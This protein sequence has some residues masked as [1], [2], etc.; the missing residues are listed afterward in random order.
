MFTILGVAIFAL[1]AGI[2]GTGLALKIEEVERN[3]IRNRKKRAATILIQ[4]AW[5]C[6]KAHTT[7][8]LVS[9][10]FRGRPMAIYKNHHY[11]STAHKFLAL[12]QLFVARNRFREL[13][14]PLDVKMVM[15]SYSDGQTEVLLRTKLIQ[16][17]IEELTRR[18]EMSENRVGNMSMRVETK[19]NTFEQRINHIRQLLESC[20]RQ[21]LANHL[22][23]ELLRGNNNRLLQNRKNHKQKPRYNSQNIAD[24][25]GMSRPSVPFESRS[26][27]PSIPFEGQVP[28]I[29]ISDYATRW[30]IGKV[31]TA[32]TTMA[33]TATDPMP[34]PTPLG[35]PPPPQPH[36]RNLTNIRP[37]HRRMSL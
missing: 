12:V 30:P 13:M 17:S 29:T 7:Y 35:K 16:Q 32:S 37:Q 27:F 21:L 28:Q 10:F 5:R 20:H 33:N 26:Q 22:L 23:V 14:R 4:R 3:Q 6:W 34:P 8:E 19:Q 9:K 25:L 2:I 24:R 18:V 1:P 11:I 36:S 31:S 15:Q